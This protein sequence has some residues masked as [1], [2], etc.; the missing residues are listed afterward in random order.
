MASPVRPSSPQAVSPPAFAP[1]TSS[2]REPQGKQNR[3][4][5]K[6]PAD[7]VPLLPSF[8]LAPGRRDILVPMGDG[9]IN[10]KRAGAASSAPTG[11][12]GP[13]TRSLRQTRSGQGCPS[14]SLWWGGQV[15]A[16][17]P[18]LPPFSLTTGRRDIL[19]PMGDAG[20][21]G[22][23]AGAASSAPT[24]GDRPATRSLRQTRSG[25]GCPSHSLW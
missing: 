14:H 2:L 13:A 17:M 8:S 22:K 24:G 9:G 23:R 20:I 3:T 6:P 5:G 12:D 21:N 25:Q 7:E 10:G 19:V 11:G 18:L 16:G 4:F 15:A 1:S